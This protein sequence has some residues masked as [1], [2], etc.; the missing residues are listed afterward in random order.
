MFVL[1]VFGALAFDV[2]Q[3]MLDRRM[4]QNAADAAAL[5]GSNYLTDTTCAGNPS[6]ANCPNALHAALQL[7]QANGYGDG[8]TNNYAGNGVTVNVK[9][10]P[11]PESQFSNL[12]GYIEVNIRSTRPSIF[13]GRWLPSQW[14]VAS[15]GV[16]ANTTGTAAPYS[17]IALN[18]TACPSVQISGNGSVVAQGS[19]QIDSS[20]A[21]G[22]LTVTGKATIDVTAPTAQ[23][24]VVGTYS[25]GGN[26][27]VTP[28]PVQSAPS[29]PDPLLDLP[30]PKPLVQPSNVVQVS[31]ATM[32]VPT[33]CPAAAGTATAAAPATCSFTSSYQNTT[34]RLF[35]G[36]YPGGLSFQG[37]TF[38]LEPGIYYLA[39]GGLNLNG[40]G[41]TIYSV[42]QNGIAP[43]A[44]GGLM[45]YNTEDSGFHTQ[46]AS[47]TAPNPSVDCLGQIN[48]DGAAAVAQLLPMQSG[49]YAGIVIFQD[50]LLSLSPT[51]TPIGSRTPDL[52]I[53]G[54]G[55]AISV[56]G[57]IY[58]PSAL[59]QVNGN[60]GSSSSSQFI[61]NEFVVTGNKG[62]SITATYSGNSFFQFKGIG[63]VQ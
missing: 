30:A 33:G 1:L 62:S 32:S 17:F 37:G 48:L 35:P 18:L 36:Y 19:V 41:A 16:A 31:G 21:S 46:C 55:G 7:A 53:N 13:T 22:A 52:K 24:D 15:M 3:A 2:G 9:I 61:A 38:Y 56:T 39:G 43:P 49:T 51:S 10:P 23:I 58:M 59:I 40:N 44:A 6:L 8:A 63:L 20:C 14:S 50:R 57:T 5:A 34:W 54:N 45:F 28:T 4:Q 26:A 11:G 42:A 27:T 25:S 12:P 29:Q 60:G 47:G